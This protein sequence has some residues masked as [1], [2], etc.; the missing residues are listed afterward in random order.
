M[1]ADFIIIALYFVCFSCTSNES[2]HLKKGDSLMDKWTNMVTANLT[3][4]A[5]LRLLAV[6]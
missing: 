4:N 5:C 6:I 3:A 1:R 2:M